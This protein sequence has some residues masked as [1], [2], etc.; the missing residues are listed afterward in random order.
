MEFSFR[1]YI[2]VLVPLR[3]EPDQKIAQIEALDELRNQRI[4]MTPSTLSDVSIP[5]FIEVFN[6]ASQYPEFEVA[7]RPTRARD[8]VFMRFSG[9]V[10]ISLEGFASL[11]ERLTELDKI[12]RAQFD[13]SV[14]LERFIAQI[15]L[16]AC[17]A[18]P[19]AIEMMDAGIV[20]IDDEIKTTRPFFSGLWNVWLHAEKRKWPLIV[21][22][23]ILDVWSWVQKLPGIADGIG[24]G[25]VGRALAAMAYLLKEEPTESPIDLVWALIGLEALYVRGKEALGEQL[26]RKTEVFLGPRHEFKKQ[27]THMYQF[28]SDLMH[29]S[30]D[31]PFP[32]NLY[33]DDGAGIESFL[34]GQYECELT[35]TAILLASLQK[36]IQNGW[37]SLEFEERVVEPEAVNDV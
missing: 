33:D 7:W 5:V 2:P 8:C 32:A 26:R 23:S 18:K 10:E 13:I 11:T 12:E 27:V 6:D 21:R 9:S 25:P 14:E 24:K 28:R 37:Y 4:E 34:N 35:A 36:L 29:G 20:F 22:M 17:I 31:I 19:G 16:A 1:C 3:F 30:V 15:A